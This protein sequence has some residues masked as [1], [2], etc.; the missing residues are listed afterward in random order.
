MRDG[1][2]FFSLIGR[3]EISFRVEKLGKNCQSGGMPGIV[4]IPRGCQESP[5]RKKG[6]FPRVSVSETVSLS[7]RR[8]E[9]AK[10]ANASFLRIG[11]TKCRNS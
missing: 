2:G 8:E 6:E 10:V 4:S 5:A 1:D 11:W 7:E 3:H 9:R